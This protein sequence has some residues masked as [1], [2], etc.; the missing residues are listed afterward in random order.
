V[1]FDIAPLQGQ[2]LEEDLR[3]RDFTINA[4][5]A[6][7]E[8][9]LRYLAEGQA[10]HPLDPLGGMADIEGRRLRAV[11]SAIFQ[12][13]PLRL[14]RAL[15]LRA[16]YRLSIDRGTQD[17]IRRDAP[18][19]LQA[20]PRRLHDELCA[21]L[22]EDGALERLRWL[23]ESGLLTTLI[24]EFVP[25]RG[26]PQPPPHYWDVLEHSLQAVDS[27]ELLASLLRRPSQEIRRSPLESDKPA[28]NL[29]DIA[30]L[31]REAEAQDIFSLSEL[32]APPMKLAAL[33]HD[34]GK[35]T[36]FT[37]DEAQQ[38]HFY[39]HPQAGVHLATRVSDRLNTSTR[40]RRLLQQVTAHHMRPGQLCQEGRVTP[41]SIR[42][43]F[44][45]LGPV[46]INVALF[47]LA[48]HLATR[49]PFIGGATEN[50]SAAWDQHVAVVSL[51]L[52]RY[53]RQRAS[54]L[55]PRLLSAEEL[56]RRFDLRP[57]PELGSLLEQIAEAQADGSVGS[58]EEAI[59][60]VEERL[61]RGKSV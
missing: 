50:T 9:A 43:Y 45:D 18:L 48:D 46:G 3:Q 21:L 2:T 52:T 49:G 41:R 1:I 8:E 51:L 33:L 37:L 11:N 44:V 15:R 59:W 29:R 38:I 28:G 10:L 57:G 14:L 47:S 55:P 58:K 35:T 34:I 4:L 5:A 53:I 39:G 17:L 27:L 24:P 25:A 16:R 60:L 31:L 22:E 26:M 13:D 54:I 32:A 7:L 42:R 12:R 36:T 56:M 6:P 19:L 30:Q 40:D 23:D 61:G 20:A